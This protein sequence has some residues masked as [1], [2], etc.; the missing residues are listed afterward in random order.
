MPVNLF[1]ANFYRAANSDLR[2]L[3]DAQALSHFQNYGLN[4]GR[5]FSPLVD[6]N[7][8]RSSN[9]D[10]SRFSN[11]Q[12][13]DHLQNY[14]VQEGRR[15]SPLADLNYYR[16]ANSDLA[17]FNNEQAFNHLQ[18][19]GVAE[20]RR[21]SSFF[22]VNFYRSHSDLSGLDN[23]QAL[24]HL[25]IHGL[26]EG[27]TFSQF[28]DIQYY[29]HSNW[30]LVRA[31]LNNNQILEHFQNYG[32]NEGRKF[33]INFDVNYY[34]SANSDLAQ[35]GLNNRQLYEHFQ[36]YGLNEGRASSQ[37]FSVS[38]YR[39]NN[40]DL[41]AARFDN[42]Q[43]Y[44][45]FV[46]YGLYEGRT[47]SN[48]STN[49][50]SS[51]SNFN[52]QFDYR[53]DTNGFFNNPLRRNAL[54]AA[55]KIWEDLIK[56]EFTN[57]PTGTNFSVT[58]P[59]TGISVQFSSDYEVDDLVVFVG[60]R[61]LGGLNG[62]LA[63][64]G[65]SATYYEG[66]SLDSRYNSL[67]NFEPWTGSISFNSSEPWFFDPTFDTAYDIPET[68]M[69]FL[70]VAVHE[71]GHILGIGASNAFDRLVSGGYFNGTN[72]KALNNGN[73]VP[74]EGDLGHVKDDFLGGGVGPEAA[75]DPT[76]PNGVRKLP[77]ALDVAILADIGYQI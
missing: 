77:T 47:G 64:A 60:A 30:D 15:F 17:S 58:N 21:F 10:L 43:L 67:N 13:F 6:L 74:L 4:E 37:Q 8:Y 9:S 5:A 22:D 49:T 23:R 32:L 76:I 40:A 14:G 51:N 73:P 54:E 69:D 50:P 20:G 26:K 38:Y 27:R 72:A 41:A 62:V 46:S 16:T 71:L 36:V 61:D 45:H 11:R 28:F 42:L 70:S 66:S 12:L 75:M 1:D 31:G 2:G 29:K 56:D 19:Y 24:Q 53:F 25:Q 7:F 57:I 48:S 59:Q 44:N 55:A 39:N 33:S 63:L 18:N 52:I 35:A 34:R 68:S 3:G 65:P